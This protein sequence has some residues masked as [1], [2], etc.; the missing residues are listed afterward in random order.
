MDVH[1]R[2]L[3]WGPDSETISGM[4]SSNSGE[5][6]GH[7]DHVIEV[8]FP[9]DIPIVVHLFGLQGVIAGLHLDQRRPIR[10]A[11]GDADKPVR[12]DGPAVKF[13]RNL[14]V[15]LDYCFLGP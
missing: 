9:G 1:D 3:I 6:I 15:S 12:S 11:I 5:L 2:W 8:V 13:E 7:R 10:L 4:R 14:G